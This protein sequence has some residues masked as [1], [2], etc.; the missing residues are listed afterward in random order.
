MRKI[1]LWLLVGLVAGVGITYMVGNKM[2]TKK[3]EQAVEQLV[4]ENEEIEALEYRD[5]KVGLFDQGGKIK[6]VRLQLKGIEDPIVID[7]LQLQKIAQ[8]E[9]RTVQADVSMEGLTLKHD[10]ALLESIT[11]ELAAMG[12]DEV[13]VDAIFAYQYDPQE[14]ELT[15]EKI[16]IAAKD[17]GELYMAFTLAQVSPALWEVEKEDLNFGSLLSTFALVSIGPS[18]IEYEDQSLFKRW[19]KRQAQKSGQRSEDLIRQWNK[20]IDTEAGRSD[21][22]IVKEALGAVKAF[23]ADP[24]RIIVR[25][26]PEK[27][28]ALMRFVLESPERMLEN[29]HLTVESD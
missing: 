15:L 12:Y 19:V 29:L 25:V 5:L 1:V 16:G 23:L 18:Q 2:A 9:G 10:H 14:R 17:M 4:A 20:Q 26:E 8:I 27:P 7:Q 28:V 22:A 13:V 24:D 3:A 21:R 6:D 11:P